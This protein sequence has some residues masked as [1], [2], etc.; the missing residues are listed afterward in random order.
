VKA[1]SSATLSCDDGN[2]NAVY[3]KSRAIVTP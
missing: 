2:G 1:D 3:V